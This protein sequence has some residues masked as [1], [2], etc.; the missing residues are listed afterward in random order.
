M[1]EMLKLSDKCFKAAIIKYLNIVRNI[2]QTC[3]KLESLSK[4]IESLRKAIQSIK[5]NQM[6]ILDL[7][8][9]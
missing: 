7:K 5:K 1:T 8:I 9:Q 3:E 6:K 2:F 4:E